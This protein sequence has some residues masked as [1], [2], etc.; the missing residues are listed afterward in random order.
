MDGLITR[1]SLVRVQSPLLNK[2]N[3][4]FHLIRLSFCWHYT[5]KTDWYSV[6]LPKIFIHFYTD[7]KKAKREPITTFN[8]LIFYIYSS[9]II[10]FWAIKQIFIAHRKRKYSSYLRIFEPYLVSLWANL[11][12]MDIQ[13]LI[14][15]FVIKNEWNENKKPD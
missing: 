15:N 9:D 6:S 10:T 1:R 13:N 14:V 8:R 4:I 2:T 12:D 5:I 11:S 7:R 3:R